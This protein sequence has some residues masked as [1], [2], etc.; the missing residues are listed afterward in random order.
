MGDSVPFS[1]EGSKVP[2]FLLLGFCT[3]ATYPFVEMGQCDDFSYVRSAKTLAET[4]HVVY[5]G[6]ASAMLGWQLA[7]G[8][9]FFKIFGFS[10]TTAY[11]SVLL[12]AL[13]TAF[14]LR[15]S[16]SFSDCTR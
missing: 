14:L 13:A 4:G 3:L 16:S 8:A 11:A 1:N 7:L 6:W 12:V 15:A 5:Y 2:H 10:F 9:L